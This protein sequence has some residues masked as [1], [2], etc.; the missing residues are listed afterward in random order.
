MVAHESLCAL[1][2]MFFRVEDEWMVLSLLKWNLHSTD[3]LGKLGVSFPFSK[4]D[5]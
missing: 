2:R 3:W 1:K 4:T 5:K